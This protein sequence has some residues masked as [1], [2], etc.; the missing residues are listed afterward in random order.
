MWCFGS[1]PA[2]VGHTAVMETSGEPLHF[3][4][5]GRDLRTIVD[6]SGGPGDRCATVLLATPGD[7]ENAASRSQARWDALRTGLAERQGCD[8][9]VLERID[10]LIETAHEKG[11]GLAVIA[12]RDA[13][14]HVEHWPESPAEDVGRWDTLPLLTPFIRVRQASPPYVVV[15][16]DR[17]GADIVACRGVGDGDTARTVN[18]TDEV[19]RKVAPGGWSQRRFQQRAE[20]AWEESAREVADAVEHVSDDVQAEVIVVAGDVRAVQLL[21]TGLPDRLQPLVREV[22]G[23]RAPGV[24]REHMEQ[25]VDRWI[26]DATA[27][28]TVKVLEKFREELGQRDRAA[29]GVDATFAALNE[30]R[31]EVLLVHDDIE[32][33]RRAWFGPDAI[34]IAEDARTLEELGV[35]PVESGRLDDVAIRAALGSGAAVWI[36]PDPGGATDGIGAVLRWG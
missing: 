32:D 1:A 30:G 33:H 16:T 23:G 12:T 3:A 13:L 17:R 22:S 29:D 31:V 20:N 18:T 6:S 2:A 9:A 10:P 36:I 7:V 24:D 28:S 34:P 27:R 19:A 8:E 26:A 5:R 21:Q 25:E 14:V 11:G 4:V 15:L 35:A